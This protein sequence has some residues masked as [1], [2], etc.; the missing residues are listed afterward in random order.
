VSLKGEKDL[1]FL[2][3]DVGVELIKGE[4]L[5]EIGLSEIIVTHFLS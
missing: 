3:K 2:Q 5:L 1:C 4:S